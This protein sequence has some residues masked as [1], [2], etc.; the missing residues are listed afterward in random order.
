MVRREAELPRDQEE[1]DM[2]NAEDLEMNTMAL[3]DA[4]NETRNQARHR[5]SNRTQAM[6]STLTGAPVGKRNVLDRDIEHPR[7]RPNGEQANL[8]AISPAVEL[9]EIDHS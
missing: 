9:A 7:R 1:T 8:S 4:R 5:A 6:Q 3:A 2:V